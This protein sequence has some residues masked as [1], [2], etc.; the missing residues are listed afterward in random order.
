MSRYVTLMSKY[1]VFF[2]FY[3][4]L[5]VKPL[6]CKI[7]KVNSSIHKR[8][9][10]SC[11]HKG[12]ILSR[13]WYRPEYFLY[14]QRNSHI[15]FTNSTGNQGIEAPNRACICWREAGVQS[16][17]QIQHHLHRDHVAE[18]PIPSLNPEWVACKTVVLHIWERHIRMLSVWFSM[19]TWTGWYSLWWQIFILGILGMEV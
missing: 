4:N 3:A 14:T 15:I 16:F 19:H 10:F 2:P 7:Q 8:R 1:S 11:E 5:F 18:Q 13:P 12:L 17:I 6:H 9:L